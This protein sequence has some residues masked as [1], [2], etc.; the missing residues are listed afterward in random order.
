MRPWSM[1][2]KAGIAR[3][4]SAVTFAPAASA[5]A[6][7]TITPMSGGV[8]GGVF[9]PCRSKRPP[10]SC[11]PTFIMCPPTKGISAY[12]Q[13]RSLPKNSRALS[14]SGVRMLIQQNSPGLRVPV[15]IGNLLGGMVAA[16]L[17]AARPER[18]IYHR[19]GAPP[20]CVCRRRGSPRGSRSWSCERR[21]VL[22]EAG[23]AMAHALLDAG[24]ERRV[25]CFLR[26]VGDAIAAG[27]CAIWAT[28]ARWGGP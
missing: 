1:M 16:A 19:N 10:M 18:R 26:R 14:G 22:V 20:R 9:G 12:V 4:P 5:L 23:V 17:R 6:T 13:P 21:Q 11:P 7:L 27:S 24:L 15:V 25:A 2:S 3:P 28:C 8:P